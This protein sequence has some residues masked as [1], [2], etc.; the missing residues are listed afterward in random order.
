MNRHYRA[1]IDYGKK[2]ADTRGL[3]WDIP[4]DSHGEA[5]DQI[6]W[7]L[8]AL[9]GEVGTVTFYL[10]DFGH[11]QSA[12]A[13]VNSERQSSGQSELIRSA[14]PAPWQDVIK[15]AAAHELF[16]RRNTPGYVAPLVVRPLRVIATCTEHAP[17]ALTVD[18]VRTSIRVGSLIQQQ[19]RF[20]DAIA[21]VVKLVFDARHLCDA[22][23]LSVVVG[24]KRVRR[25]REDK[26]KHVQAED[27]LR[28][29]LESRKRS[30]RLPDRRAFW[31][32]ARIVM[33]ERP[34]SFVDEIKFAAI[35][36]MIVTGFR[37]GEAALLPIDW[38]RV[39]RHVDRNGRPSGESG[40]FSTSLMIRHFAEKQYENESD[41]RVLR[42][43]AQPVPEMFRELIEET[44]KRVADLTD[45]LRQ[46]L[47][48]QCE[49]GRLLPWYSLHEMVPIADL[50]TRLTGNAFWRDIDRASYLANYRQDFDPNVLRALRVDQL[51]RERDGVGRLDMPI[52]IWGN[53]LRAMMREG[54][55]SLRFRSAD[56]RELNGS[57]IQWSSA[58]F[59]ADE[60]EAHIRAIVP[61][62]VS[63]TTPLPLSD[64]AVQPWEL[65][66]ILPKRSLAEERNDGLCDVTRFIAINRP[67]PQFIGQALGDQK[68]V[69]SLFEKYGLTDQDRKLRLRSHSLRHLQNT[70]LFR[71][72]VADTM[73]TKR[74]NRRS[75]V[76]SYEYD[77]RS[78]AEEL[79]AIEIPPEVEAKLGDKATTVAKLIKGGRASGPIVD[80]FRRIEATEGEAAAFDF[81]S[82]EADGFHATPYGHCINSFTVD[83]CPQ[84]L[85]CFNNCRHLSATNLPEHRENLVKLESKLVV[86]IRAIQE[87]PAKSIGWKNQLAHAKVRLNG[88]QQLLATPAGQAVFPDGVDRSLR[89][90]K[91]LMDG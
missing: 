83:P 34:Q 43:A 32:L 30:E 21:G 3:A 39:Q 67:D 4:L 27:V 72:G 2:L 15:A 86:A 48:L 51:A 50:Y 87:R 58:H 14:V 68:L 10:R 44:L 53:R 73:I 22:G 90:S 13:A 63:D 59:R 41:S 79:D 82:V 29:N 88:V 25:P 64:G 80:K 24:A 7:N 62:K 28:S 31:E 85:E 89:P 17:W 5:I 47:K 81:L 65:L 70:E 36:L 46:T 37:I 20:A 84:H 6:G 61:T 74:F 23:P 26:A 38:R 42:V 77:H 11:D 91:G 16:V 18:D 49:T 57:R 45:P 54:T 1:F 69:P 9:V 78:L 8:S 71:L 52:Y 35:R 19:G 75:V 12:L 60:F 33:T 66:F 56:G 55:T 76:Q 40:G